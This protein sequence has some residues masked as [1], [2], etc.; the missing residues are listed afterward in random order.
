M[1]VHQLP[2]SGGSLWAVW[3]WGEGQ[4]GASCVVRDLARRTEG[5]TA[6]AAANVFHM[7]IPH[8]HV[9]LWFV[10][11]LLRQRPTARQRQ[12]RAH[13]QNFLFLLA[14]LLF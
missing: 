12:R 6:A 7:P 1:Y 11:L 3:V 2:G 10:C 8:S 4:I 5:Q 13:Y 9:F 14:V